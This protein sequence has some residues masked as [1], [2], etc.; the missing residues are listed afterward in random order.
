MFKELKKF[1]NKYAPKQST[2]EK[3]RPRFDKSRGKLFSR[4]AQ[5]YDSQISGIE[6]ENQELGASGVQD[7]NL[8]HE[9][10]DISEQFFSPAGASTSDASS[11]AGNEPVQLEQQGIRRILRAPE[12]S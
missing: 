10:H 8:G 4:K 9:Y 5:D 11:G 3:H 1:Y 6:G 2:P 12:I 7:E